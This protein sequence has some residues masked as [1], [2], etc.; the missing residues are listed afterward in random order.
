M[1]ILDLRNIYK[2]YGKGDNEVIAV[3]GISIKV[4]KGDIIAIM[5]PSGCGKSTLL[6][7]LGC[8][9]TPS[10]GEYYIDDF[11]VDFK[12][13]NQLSKIRNEKISFI[14]QNFALIKDLSVLENVMLPLKF[15]GI[16]RKERVNK[17]IKYLNE[18]DIFNLKNKS[19]RQLSGG[20][21][22]RV[23]IARALTQE[24][25]IILADEPTGALDQEN[26][27]KIMKILQELN[28][29]HNKTILVVT[30]DNLVA[31]FCNKTLKMKDGKWDSIK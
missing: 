21:Q 5:G 23:A 9:D 2:T 8:I 19:I 6:N 25:E 13:L 1:S 31:R 27:I 12:K 22:Q 18:L 14:F 15:R 7:I 10:Q 16:A 17:A 20:Q 3:D 24:S 4:D 29:K 11:Q 30:H 26:S 28:Q